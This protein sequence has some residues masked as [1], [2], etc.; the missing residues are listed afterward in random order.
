M[1]MADAQ[2]SGHPL[3][4][5]RAATLRD[6]AR[7]RVRQFLTPFATLDEEFPNFYPRLIVRGSGVYLY[8]D[9]GNRL[10][11]GG[12][13]LGACQIGHGR[14]EMA[15]RIATQ[16]E[17]LE[18]SSLEQG[19]SHL[20]AVELAERLSPLVPVDE[21]VFSLPCTGSE[22][23]ETALKVARAHHH[24]RGEAGKI[25]VLAR[26]GSYHGSSLGALSATGLPGLRDP[27]IPLTPGFVRIPQASPGRCGYCSWDAQCTLGCVDGIEA[28]IRAEGPETIA[29]LIAEPVA[30]PQCVQIPHPDYWGAVQTLCRRY[31]ILL[32]VDEVVTGF[33][34]TGRFFGSE[35]WNI[36]PDIVT[37]AKG[38]TSGYVPLGCV[39]VSGAVSEVFNKNPLPHVNT[40]LAHPVACAAA[41][42]N[43]AILARD[44]LI[45]AARV[46]QGIVE[47]RFRTLA[48]R[49]RRELR[50]AAIGL[51]TGL[52][53]H[54]DDGESA[55]VLARRIRYEC[56]QRGLLV[57]TVADAPN[58][59]V[60]FY[61]PLIVTE[62][63]LHW[64]CDVIADVLADLA[65]TGEDAR[66]R[67]A[68]VEQTGGA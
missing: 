15:A 4:R 13:H 10:L 40:Y 59:A 44:N 41:L 50:I 16:I 3:D 56:Y 42:E 65:V 8:D 19:L 28:A 14:K 38:I 57:R 67:P 30:I 47:G 46:G 11:D 54:I 32:I 21:P 45:E 49:S 18:Y 12:H 36:R 53:F 63:E 5:K 43:I 24:F 48:T 55:P 39:A 66:R 27:F 2:T 35:H 37:M 7:R 22:A 26:T 61:P 31:G 64:A 68:L 34:R 25:K 17:T 62:T 60:I 6:L 1:T 20:T 9:E 29:A 33:G 52:D 23:N 58:V 51:L